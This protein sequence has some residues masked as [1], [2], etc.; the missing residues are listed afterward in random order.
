ML[1]LHKRQR[2]MQ[3]GTYD[4]ENKWWDVVLFHILILSW[5]LNRIQWEGINLILINNRMSFNNLTQHKQINWKLY[6]TKRIVQSLKKD[7]TVQGGKFWKHNWHS[8]TWELN[9]E[10]K[11]RGKRNTP[12]VLFQNVVFEAAVVFCLQI[13]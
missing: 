9:F 12:E 13:V 8:V 7:L 11:I 6:C 10:I 3:Y 4:C 1:E 2:D 5:R